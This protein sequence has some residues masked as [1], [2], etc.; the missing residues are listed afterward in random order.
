MRERA[1]FSYVSFGWP[2]PVSIVS[3]GYVGTGGVWCFA[4][5]TTLEIVAMLVAL[6]GLR[7]W[8]ARSV[9]YVGRS[10]SSIIAVRLRPTWIQP[11][12]EVRELWRVPLA[13]VRMTDRAV[14]NF[15]LVDFDGHP[16]WVPT[17]EIDSL[18]AG[19]RTT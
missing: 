6:P 12:G 18:L 17:D 16:V 3:K 9:V 14:G 19:R 8:S 7:H 13:A 10:G 15:S 11:P 2:E 4:A 5:R 1:R